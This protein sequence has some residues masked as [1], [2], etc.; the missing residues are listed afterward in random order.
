[1]NIKLISK[2]ERPRERLIKN[3]VS[4]LSDAEVLAI[5]LQSGTK[6]MS[7]ID[8]ARNL[9]NKYGLSNLFN[10]SYQELIKNI[11]IKEAKATKIICSFE[12]AK[13]CLREETCKK[14]LISVN[15]AYNFIKSD[16]IFSKI[17]ECYIILLD[18][19]C[20]VIKKVKLS[21]GSVGEVGVSFKK[22]INYLLIYEA[23]GIIICHNHPSGDPTPSRE[24]KEL[25]SRLKRTLDELNFQMYDHIIIG[26]NKYFSFLENN[27]LECLY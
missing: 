10:I 1:M 27:L 23:S 26:K 8:L 2:E 19:K 16:F 9:L 24:D 14:T 25:T 6:E 21:N 7:A 18:V 5:I 11:G 4:V 3:D 15:D 17:E 13:R 20:R 12:L 22:I